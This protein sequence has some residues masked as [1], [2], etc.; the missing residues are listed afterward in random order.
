MPQYAFKVRIYGKRP[1]F[2]G[3]QIPYNTFNIHMVRI[4]S[5]MAIVFLAL[6]R[7]IGRIE[8][9]SKLPKNRKIDESDY[10]YRPSVSNTTS[11]IW[12]WF[13]MDV[14]L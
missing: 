9:S 7:P 8:F 13:G 4:C 12:M 5:A 2:V 1:I 11:Q 6:L 3:S 14:G 10:T